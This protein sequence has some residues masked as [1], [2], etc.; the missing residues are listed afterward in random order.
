M[1]GSPTQPLLYGFSPTQT[2]YSNA[3]GPTAA[4]A[5]PSAPG[6]RTHTSSGSR[7]DPRRDSLQTGTGTLVTSNPDSGSGGQRRYP[8]EKVPGGPPVAS[9]S[10]AGGRS[11]A[12]DEGLLV[13]RIALRLADMLTERVGHAPPGAGEM[14][15]GVLPP[16]DPEDRSAE[17]HQAGPG[18]SSSA[19]QPPHATPSPQAPSPL[20]PQPNPSAPHHLASS[21]PS[22]MTRFGP[23]PRPSSSGPNRTSSISI[24]PPNSG[25]P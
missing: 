13:D 15:M 1:P 8:P 5:V 7:S 14:E 23:R 17:G 11:E 10:G 4:A 16:Y 22:S 20:S 19:A 25:I 12:V 6:P 9:G 2:A 21:P 18:P 3:S 24:S